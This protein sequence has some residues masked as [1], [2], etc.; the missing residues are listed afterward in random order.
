[1]YSNVSRSKIY[2]LNS[3]V[4]FAEY[5]HADAFTLWTLSIIT[6]TAPH[7]LPPTIIE[8]QF[9][10]SV[11]KKI[12]T[13]GGGLDTSRNDLWYTSARVSDRRRAEDSDKIYKT[14]SLVP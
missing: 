5:A 4:P 12:T 7:P 10:D 8:L 11:H 9:P 14:F 1:M 6:H 2:G 13:S 3:A